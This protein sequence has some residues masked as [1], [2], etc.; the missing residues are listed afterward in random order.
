MKPAL[1]VVSAIDAALAPSGIRTRSVVLLD[2]GEGPT[3]LSGDPARSI[4]LLGNIGGSVWP[5]LSTWLATYG[6]PD[7]LDTWSKA[8]IE[9]VATQ[10]GATAFYPSD[11]PYMPFQQW[12]MRA[13]GLEA[14]PLGILIHPEYG[15]WHGYRG[16]LALGEAVR[17]DH[18]QRRASPCEACDAKPCLSACP[19]GAVTPSGFSVGS[20]RTYLATVEAHTTCMEKGCLARHACPVGEAY[21]YPPQQIRFH[22]AALFA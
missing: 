12:A 17:A 21:R 15:L 7:P 6:G 2:E 19:V 18:A 20:C 11:R 14:S 10:F 4:V 8:V 16:A 22:M 1:D 3:L 13:E 9:P 5:A